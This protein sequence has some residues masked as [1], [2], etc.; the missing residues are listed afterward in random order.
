M[1]SVPTVKVATPPLRLFVAR[2]VAPSLKVTVPLGVPLPG[3]VTVT[4]AVKVIGWPEAEGLAEEAKVVV[5]L[6]G[7]TV[8]V[9]ESVGVKLPESA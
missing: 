2:A 8:S 9:P 3:G 6:A 7:V 4:V 1:E 5:V